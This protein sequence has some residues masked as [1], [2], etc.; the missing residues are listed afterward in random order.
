VPF[1]TPQ[2]LTMAESLTVARAGRTA[3]RKISG[4]MPSQVASACRRAE[5][6]AD[7]AARIP[8]VCRGS[9]A[10]HSSQRIH[11]AAIGTAPLRGPELL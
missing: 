5:M 1:E 8:G 11:P 9:L 4:S 3:D 2:A 6:A 10:M 7:R